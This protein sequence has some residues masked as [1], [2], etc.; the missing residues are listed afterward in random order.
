MKRP[1][2]G[3]H[4]DIFTS[5]EDVLKE[6]RR[7][8]YER[9]DTTLSQVDAW[10]HLGRKLVYDVNA[11]QEKK[12]SNLMSVS[13]VYMSVYVQGTFTSSIPYQLC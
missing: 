2:D 13:T 10:V 3:D 4:L 7:E 6:I 12:L 5:A 9:A 1:V 11:C 8:S